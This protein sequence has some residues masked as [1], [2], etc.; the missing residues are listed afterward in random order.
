MRFR[1]YKLCTNI[2]WVNHFSNSPDLY[3]VVNNNNLGRSLNI[4]NQNVKDIE[5]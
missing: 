1:S 2:N 5:M 4:Q 3:H